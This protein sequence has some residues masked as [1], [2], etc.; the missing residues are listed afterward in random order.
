MDEGE[1]SGVQ[2]AWS[3]DKINIICATIAF[4]MGR[5]L[6]Q[7]APDKVKDRFTKL[8]KVQFQLLSQSPIY[9]NIFTL[10]ISSYGVDF[11]LS[12]G[13]DRVRT[14]SLSRN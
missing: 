5:L 7:N 12:R 13:L 10:L 11:N 2:R 14:D 8:F 4:G 3:E 9:W 6:P 1:R